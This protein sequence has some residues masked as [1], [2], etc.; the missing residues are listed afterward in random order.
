MTLRAI[1]GKVLTWYDGFSRGGGDSDGDA[2]GVAVKARMAG[3]GGVLQVVGILLL[4][5]QGQAA[6]RL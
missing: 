1:T 4:F 6:A 5:A 2:D 3:P